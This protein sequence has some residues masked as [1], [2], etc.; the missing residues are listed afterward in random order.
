MLHLAAMSRYPMKRG[1]T[2]G[3]WFAVIRINRLLYRGL[4]EFDEHS[5]PVPSLARWSVVSPLH[6]RFTLDE[7]ILRFVNGM[8]LTARH[9]KASLDFILDEANGSPHRTTLDMIERIEAPD[10]RTL[11]FYLGRPDV[12]LWY[13]DEIFVAR[14]EV[15]G[16][17]V[18]G[19]GNYD[20]LMRVHKRGISVAKAQHRRNSGR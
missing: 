14:Q 17:R 20:G 13:E 19:D 9:V 15:E 16:Y 1:V 4:V 3:G 12:P 5:R 6:Y 18:A 11:N 8:R 7:S 2:A 10:E